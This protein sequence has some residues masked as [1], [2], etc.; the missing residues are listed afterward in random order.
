MPFSN[1][2]ASV[3]G[4]SSPPCAWSDFFLSSLFSFFFSVSELFEVFSPD[5]S[6]FS[7]FSAEASVEEFA[8]DASGASAAVERPP[9]VPSSS[10]P[11]AA[12]GSTRASAAVVT[13]MLF[14]VCN[15]T[16]YLYLSLSDPP[17]N[18]ARVGTSDCFLLRFSVSTMQS[19]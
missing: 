12:S 17:G 14:F 2:L 10:D 1:G 19:R 3:G 16:V 11:H 6:D 15:F 8:A 18:S 5:F 9:E 13:A 7:D 4:C